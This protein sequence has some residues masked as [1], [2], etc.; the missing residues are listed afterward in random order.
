MQPQDSLRFTR[1]LRGFWLALAWAG[2]SAAVSAQALPQQTLP[3]RNALNSM[4]VETQTQCP[5]QAA[6]LETDR[7]ALGEK[8]YRLK[9][10]AHQSI[11]QC[12]PAR[13]N[14][15]LQ[16]R[17][18]AELSKAVTEQ[19]ALAFVLE[20]VAQPCAATIFRSMFGGN[21]CGQLMPGEICDCLKPIVVK[22]T[23]AELVQA[24][25]AY[26]QYMGELGASRQNNTAR[27]ASPPAAEK[28]MTAISTCRGGAQPRN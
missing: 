12:Q 19:Q 5:R 20:N 1:F 8:N 2:G 3:L 13:I 25:L 28:L 24:G 7:K 15:L 10:E 16:Q 9:V 14:S 27:P 18:E 6:S 21:S 26:Q 11:C 23:D 4:L 17:P 22:F